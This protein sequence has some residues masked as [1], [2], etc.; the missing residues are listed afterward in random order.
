MLLCYRDRPVANRTFLLRFNPD[1][2]AERLIL[3]T[4]VIASVFAFLHW[5]HHLIAGF[6]TTLNI[7]CFSIKPKL[8]VDHK[9]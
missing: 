5:S 3:H 1:E 7:G 8:T 2:K 9:A 4:A 6:T